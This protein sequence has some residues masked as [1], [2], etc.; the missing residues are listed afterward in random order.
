S[1]RHARP[2]LRQGEGGVS[3]RLSDGVRVTSTLTRVTTHTLTPSGWPTPLRRPAM[4]NVED[5]R[6]GLELTNRHLVLDGAP[7][8]PVSGE[9][10]YSRV[11]RARWR[12]RLE[13]MRSGGGTDAP[14]YEH[15]TLPVV[16]LVA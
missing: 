11:P 5:P 3:G 12:E 10:H 1:W 15:L 14:V 16:R 13:L 4:A 2:A 6:P 8:V 9:I 7:T